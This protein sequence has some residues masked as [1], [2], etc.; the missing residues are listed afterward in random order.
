[1]KDFC[2][3]IRK[4]KV[5]IC[6]SLTIMKKQTNWGFISIDI[7]GFWASSFLTNTRHFSLFF[8]NILMAI[9]LSDASLL[10]Q[11]NPKAETLYSQSSA[12]VDKK[13]YV[14]AIKLLNQTIQK[15]QKFADAYIRLADVY[16]AIQDTQLATVN[17]RLGIKYATTP[18]YFPYFKLGLIQFEQMQY[19]TAAAL[20]QQAKNSL[21][22]KS[23]RL[24]EVDKYLQNALFS[25]NALK[26]PQPFKPINL[27]QNVNS[28][29]NEYLPALSAD[30]EILVFTRQ[31]GNE[32]FYE[33]AIQNGYYQPAIRLDPPLNTDE[34]EGG[35][36][37]SADGQQIFL[38]ACNRTDGVG[39]C[40]LYTSTR[41]NNGTWSKPQNLGTTI[42]TN[43]WESQPS[44]SRDGN[45]LYFASTRLGGKGK[46]DIWV[47]QKNTNDNQ[48]STPQNLEKINTEETE[49]SPFIHPDSQTLYFS[50]NGKTGLGDYDLYLS[51]SEKGEFKT[52]INLGYPI[53]TAKSERSISINLDGTQGFFSAQRQGGFGGMDIYAFQLPKNIQ[54]QRVIYFKGAIKNEANN[55][56]IDSAFLSVIDLKNKEIIYNNTIANGNKFLICLNQNEN[57]AMNI[58]K[59]GFLF[60]SENFALDSNFKDT[61]NAYVI[62]LKPIKAGASVALKNIFF[63]SNSFILKAQS[64]NELQTLTDF[65]KQN[66]DTHFEIR[67][68]TD[69][70][71]NEKNNQ[72]LSTQRAKQVY[73]TLLKT[74]PNPQRLTYKGFGS[75]KPIASNQTEQGKSQN[76]RTEIVVVKH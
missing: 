3:Y 37:L 45:T 9:V 38:T 43:A 51:R 50:S 24:K 42:N 59:K 49:Y 73:E 46:S 25:A 57:Y 36:C 28:V 33:T 18:N 56:T 4:D 2:V 69:D 66:P 40:D 65:F 10:A 44:I 47:S 14:E 21:K 53:N 39:S 68:H 29:F 26:N 41:Q 61:T 34:N 19:D 30:G 67:G 75:T 1:M 7:M 20:F 35:H 48:W 15:D 74:I 16:L 72:T 63:E 5:K 32:D 71:G 70:T 17:Y 54:P 27:G 55:Q 64:I 13:N 22:P 62:Y 23:F 76:R 31:E 58:Q 8:G 60:Y 12:A 6:L 52:A 11:G